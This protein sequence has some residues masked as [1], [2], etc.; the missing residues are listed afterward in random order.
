MTTLT[1]A[2]SRYIGD[3]LDGT[4]TT[5]I[6]ANWERWVKECEAQHDLHVFY[7]SRFSPNRQYV[8]KCKL[9]SVKILRGSQ[10][11]VEDARKDGFET[12]DELVDALIGL[13]GMSRAMVLKSKWAVLEMG[14][15]LDGPYWPGKNGT[16]ET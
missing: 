2:K 11:K 12:L 15:W 14:E 4:K 16:A 9:V 3:M 6:R 13:N 10:F 1:F 8:G 7:G 5:T